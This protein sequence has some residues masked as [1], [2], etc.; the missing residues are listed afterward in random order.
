MKGSNWTKTAQRSYPSWFGEIEH[1]RASRVFEHPIVLPLMEMEF[2][3]IELLYSDLT[4]KIPCL[5]AEEC[6]I[7]PRKPMPSVA[8]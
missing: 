2:L 1:G 8:I 6:L 5:E 4:R 3:R 7:R